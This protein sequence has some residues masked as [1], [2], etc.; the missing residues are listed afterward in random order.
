M[1]RCE[2]KILF[3]MFRITFFIPIM[4]IILIDF[5]GQNI[6]AAFHNSISSLFTFPYANFSW[7]LVLLINLVIFLYAKPLIS[8]WTKY[9][10]G[11]PISIKHKNISMHIFNKLNKIITLMCVSGFLIGA[12]SGHDDLTNNFSILPFTYIIA[13]SIA[14]GLFTVTLIVMS[15]DDILFPIK[16]ALMLNYPE[17]KPRF[18]SFFR[19]MSKT[20]LLLL[21]FL[22]F[23]IFS[24]ATDFYDI[25]YN[26]AQSKNFVTSDETIIDG[27]VESDLG[28]VIE[29][30]MEPEM[31]FTKMGTGHKKTEDLVDVLVFKIIIY[32]LLSL[33]ALALLKKSIKNPL[34]TVESRLEELTS[35][36]KKETKRIEIVNNDEFSLIYTDI[37]KLI[38]MQETEL[39]IS[40]ERLHSV[41]DNAADPIVSFDE[42]GHIYIFNPAA[43]LFFGWDREQI[44]GT[45]LIQL[46]DPDSD[47]CKICAE[48]EQ[49][50]IKVVTEGNDDLQRFSGITS[51]GDKV[52]FEANFSRSE[53]P[54]GAIY[55]AVI[56]DISKQLEF[57]DSLKKAKSSAERAN[58]LKSEFLA[59]MSHELRTPL[60]AVLGFTQLL[61]TDKNLTDSQVDKLNTI[62]RSGEHLLAL[63]NDILDISKIEAGKI[64]LH[65]T[66]FNLRDFSED[67]K[68]MLE[69]KC[70]NKGLSLYIEYVD[71]IP[72]YVKADLGKLRQIMINILGNA[73]K[74]TK[75]G[76]IA[77]VVGIENDKLRFSV[78]DT[79]K[80]IPTD[81]ISSILQPFTQSSITDNEGGTGLGLA[82]TN[83]FI[84]MM[85]GQ[86]E[87]ESKEDVG[88]T[89][90]FGVDYELAKGAENKEDD[91]GTVLGIENDRHPNVVIV[92]DKINNRLILKEMLERVGFVTIEA[93]NGLEA[94]KRVKEVK[95]E[96]VFM[97]IKMPVLD[98]YGAVKLIKED[99]SIKDIPVFALTASAFKHDEKSI[100]ESG[101]DGFLAKPFKLSSLFRLVH[102]SSDIKFIYETKREVIKKISIDSLNFKEIIPLIPETQIDELDDLALIN[103]FA[104]IKNILDGYKDEPK[105]TAFVETVIYYTDN[106]DDDN[107]Q[108]VIEKLKQG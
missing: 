21:A 43:E 64:E 99:E 83:S 69:L 33:R 18:Q 56:R 32:F 53:T 55:T 5:K 76:G 92:D 44:K 6:E 47:Y 12:M 20:M 16:S 14:T 97:D 94:V 30:A 103:D 74:F 95:P 57:E 10:R 34:K 13:E 36:S 26:R 75:E 35:D 96:L 80:G 68:Q 87:I 91:L 84:K 89:F 65:E 105:L 61:N 66:T 98:G 42:K 15:L 38:D 82:I 48:D 7:G 25:A 58:E 8:F 2:K 79:G 59:N 9:N 51:T 22:G 54:D 41:I 81:E 23:Q 3:K 31:F 67:L 24:I 93:E 102:D 49:K 70:K 77:I 29:M 90:S 106:F 63:I 52:S 62:S 17:V 19:Q 101:F 107:L 27:D 73:I 39:G 108:I 86:L 71:P 72:V 85:G 88:S 11:E 50:F 78:N 100:L 40:Q 37:N 1:D 60:N 4:M 104:G 28:T 45:S 46:F